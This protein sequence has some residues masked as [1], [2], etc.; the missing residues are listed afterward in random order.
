V[1]QNNEQEGIKILS[2]VYEKGTKN[3]RQGSTYKQTIKNMNR[4]GKEED[5]K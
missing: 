1:Y 4:K 5:E 2:V 3:R